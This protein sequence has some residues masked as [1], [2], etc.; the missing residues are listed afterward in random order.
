MRR[1]RH[2]VPPIRR[3][4]RRGGECVTLRSVTQIPRWLVVVVGLTGACGD[5]GRDS[6][7][8]A[9][10]GMVLEGTHRIADVEGW[11]VDEGVEDPFGPRP[12]GT[13]C[14][15]GFG[16]EGGLFEVDTGICTWGTFVQASA[17]PVRA[18]D[19]L[20]LVL[21]HDTLS[22]EDEGAVSVVGAAIADR[23]VWTEEIPIPSP[24]GFLRPTFDSPVDAPAG[25]PLRL[26]VHNHGVN[27]YRFVDFT[28]THR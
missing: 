5:D 19:E 8:S 13:V 2:P 11:S 1:N 25:T 24:N 14:E 18:G 12:S 23:I 7:S 3:E 4:C 15:A 22:S 20:E 10:T 27:N 28:V 6:D 16:E 9:S 17:W 26:H 21:V